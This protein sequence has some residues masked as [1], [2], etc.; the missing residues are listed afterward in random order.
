MSS[1]KKRSFSD[2]VS[3]PL[4]PDHLLEHLVRVALPAK[5]NKDAMKQFFCKV[6][7][8]PDTVI[9]ACKGLLQPWLYDMG[10]LRNP[11]RYV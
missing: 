9:K 3:D 4:H 2:A 7:T 8:K 1:P 10:N 5:C 6:L 11:E